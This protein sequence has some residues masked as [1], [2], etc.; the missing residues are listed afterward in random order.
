MK[1]R[2]MSEPRLSGLNDEQDLGTQ[3]ILKSSNQANPDADNRKQGNA[4][5]LPK[6]WEIKKL[7]EVCELS[8]GGDVP[9]D[10]FSEIQTEKYKTP[11]YANGE[12][13]EGLYG[14]TSIPKITKPSITVSARGTIGFSVKRLE[15]FFPVVR[16]IV[17]TPKNLKELELDFLDYSLKRIDFKH[18]G[19]SIPQL[20][21]P[22][23]RDYEIPLPPLPE[24]QRIVSI[25][26]ECFAAIDKAKANA[27]QNL[28]NA[29][30]LFE[31]YLQGVFENGN[32]ETKTIQEITKVVNGYAFASKDFKPT[33]TVKSVKITNVGVKE[34]VE[35]ADNY[36]PEKFKETLKDFQVREGNIVIALTRTIISAGLKV[37]VVPASYDGALVNQRVAAL[38]PNEKLA[39]QNF[40]YYFLTTSGVA[41]YV[42][43]HV[44][45][46]MQPNLSIN[47]LKNLPVP[48]PPL[49]EQQTIVRQLDAL[50]AETQKLEAV[51]QKKI[52]DL[53]ELKKSILQKAFS[54]Q[55][56]ESG[57]V[58]LKDEQDLSNA[59]K[60]G[61]SL[62]QLNPDSDKYSAN[63]LI[64]KSCF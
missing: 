62:N 58:G 21:V 19:S 10:S 23:I 3:K 15:A 52:A 57:L 59:K 34:F 56:S 50:R 54:G 49:Q 41:K 64:Q 45:T 17:V 30:E 44:N 39:N 13:N 53:E 26:D 28:K 9:K 5:N 11:I 20:T 46:L 42:L 2:K 48:C 36:L 60:S 51:Y 1:Q 55:L 35:E 33:N 37:A 61:K 31:S 16:L 27:E 12:K 22:M 24:Q 29:K 25:L 47:D 6:G 4:P 38:V 14:Y 40:L 7:G 32:W 63:P 8:A 43:A 18:S